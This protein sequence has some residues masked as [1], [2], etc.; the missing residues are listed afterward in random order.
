MG[1]KTCRKV[2][3]SGE[4]GLESFPGKKQNEGIEKLTSAMQQANN[5][6]H[7]VLLLCENDLTASRQNMDLVQRAQELKE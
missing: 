3:L 7:C 6:Q 5:Q 1:S 4:G 2:E